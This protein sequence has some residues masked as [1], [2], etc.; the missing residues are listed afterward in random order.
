MK[1]EE[2]KVCRINRSVQQKGMMRV[3][4]KSMMCA[5]V[6]KRV[7]H[8][9]RTGTK[10]KRRICSILRRNSET[11]Q[12]RFI[13]SLQ[14]TESILWS[15][16]KVDL[17]FNMQTQCKGADFWIDLKFGMSLSNKN[18]DLIYFF[19]KSLALSTNITSEAKVSR[20]KFH[21]HRMYD[22]QVNVLLESQQF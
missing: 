2:K 8:L 22:D 14:H 16:S 17:Q 13:L 11:K 12:R 1:K 20:R 4:G 15:S 19:L 3:K 6:C 7:I 21:V 5:L 9:D 10:R 18:K